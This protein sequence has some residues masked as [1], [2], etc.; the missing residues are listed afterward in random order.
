MSAPALELA[1]LGSR[2]DLESND[3]RGTVQASFVL[4]NIRLTVSGFLL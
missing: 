4:F 1:P 3:L 2:S